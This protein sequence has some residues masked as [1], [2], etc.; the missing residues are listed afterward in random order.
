[1][2]SM[3]RTFSPLCVLLVLLM[4]LFCF[5]PAL[6]SCE[7]GDR[8]DSD[9][10]DTSAD[11]APDESSDTEPADAE[12]SFDL[13]VNGEAK[14][15]IIRHQDLDS[16]D[17]QVKAAVTIRKQFS[18]S[19]GVDVPIEDDWVKL[20]GDHDHDTLEILV[21]Y[22]NYSETAEA[23]QKLK[24]G[25]F[26]LTVVGNKIV[27]LGYT[28]EAINAAASALCSAI[29]ANV[30]QDEGAV[31]KSVRI[32][33][34]YLTAKGTKNKTISDMPAFDGT[35]SAYYEGGLSTDELIFEDATVDSYNA[36]VQKLIDAGYKKHTETQITGNR[37]ATLY[38]DRFTVTAGYYDYNKNVRVLIQPFAPQSLLAT[39]AEN[40]TETVTTGQITMIGLE[41]KKSDGGYASNGLSIL[42]R[43]TDGRFIVV[44][45]GFSGN[46][47]DANMLINTMK[48]QSS[49]YID[50]TGGITVALWIVTHA[51]ADHSGMINTKA[52]SFRSANIKIEK[53]LVNFLSEKELKKARAAYA[54][55]WSETEGN[56][57][58]SSITAASTVGA[59]V[60]T[61][62]VGQIF[63]LANAK[64]EV[65]YTID[66]YAPKAANALNTTSL[67]IRMTFTDPV[68]K[69]ETVYMSTGDAT[70]PGFLITYNMYGNYLKSDIVQVAHHGATTWGAENGTISA[71]KAMA[72]ETLL[73]P[74]GKTAYENYRNK[75]YNIV[76]WN[77]GNPNYKETYVAGTE[78]NLTVIPLPYVVGTGTQTNP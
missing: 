52:S 26:L 5:A 37:F 66:S 59:E 74:V 64:L 22:T 53:F 45:G 72:P 7:N 69:K 19:A 67:I 76:L 62:R 51:H 75:A 33:D 61:A 38:N 15:K 58:S 36:Y 23:Q 41:Y 24:Y 18:A 77:S 44:D 28:E 29:R 32:K 1:M 60:V 21:G 10:A 34:V 50:K 71:Y 30:T 49:D 65:L 13:V 3:K 55:N 70:G 16:S 54:A 63:Y 11:S 43:L 8:S 39:E 6:I 46:Q 4:I 17:P 57:W 68:T 20:G 56:S 31:T 42:I 2:F 47:N 35:F 12:K 27:V 9:T 73:W 78:G 48:M 14:V 40:V 25:D